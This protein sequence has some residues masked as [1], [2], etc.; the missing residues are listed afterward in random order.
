MIIV[1]D[2]LR[3]M[4]E[5]HEDNQQQFQTKKGLTS[6]TITCTWKRTQAQ[7]PKPKQTRKTLLLNSTISSAIATRPVLPQTAKHAYLQGTE[8]G[9]KICLTRV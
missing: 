4:S 5:Q 1:Q 7:Y 8:D 9:F 6:F 2:V 3:I